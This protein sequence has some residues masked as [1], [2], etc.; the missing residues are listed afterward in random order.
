M[1]KISESLLTQDH[2][3]WRNNKTLQVLKTF[4]QYMNEKYSFNNV[5]LDILSEHDAKEYINQ[6]FVRDNK[7]KL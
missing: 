5:I 7:G 3:E 6:H 4:G 2:E 1:A